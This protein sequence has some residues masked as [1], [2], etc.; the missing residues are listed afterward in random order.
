MDT[1][2]RTAPISDGG[3]RWSSALA[4]VTV[5]LAAVVAVGLTREPGTSPSGRTIA[6]GGPT[7]FAPD[8]WEI[9]GAGVRRSMPADFTPAVNA[10]TGFVTGATRL[11]GT[12]RRRLPQLSP[13]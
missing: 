5:A 10:T 2:D 11:P 12:V 4:V 7:A 9:R 13:I 1:P 8:R 3:P 6:P